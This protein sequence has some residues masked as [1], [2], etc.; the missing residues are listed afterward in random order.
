MSRSARILLLTP[1]YPPAAGGIQQLLGRLV[2]ELAQFEVTVVTRD[3]AGS[4]SWT[5]ARPHRV[6][7][8]GSSQS[9]LGLLGPVALGAVEGLR[10]QF[11]L[12]L[13]GHVTCVPT[14]L[15]LHRLRGQPF[16]V[17]LYADELPRHRHLLAAGLRYAAVTIA[18]SR[19]TRDLAAALGAPVDRTVIVP[20]GVDLPAMPAM[21]ADR[22]PGLV[23]TVARLGDRYKGHDVML[24]ALPHLRKLVPTARW[25]VIGDGPLR[26][27]LEASARR[28][29]VADVV[30]FAGR[31]GD[32]QRDE[33]LDRA[34]VFAMPSRLP[35]RLG[36]EGF[37]IVYLEA[38][39]HGLPVVAGSV[40]GALDAVADG[41]TGL[42]VDPTSPVAVAEALAR[43]LNDRPLARTMALAS[44]RH[45]A[46]FAYDLIADR[47][48]SALARAMR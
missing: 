15:L 5:P 18:I 21:P 3:C 28:L 12:V 22:E 1:D 4:S 6:R 26:A 25:L 31:V 45:A 44:R 42:L 48:A 20:P 7:R 24:E 47:V 30:T 23:V 16:A 41:E 34:E 39:A 33:W 11:D 35:E 46:T 2:E 14:A 17:Y 43:I 9:K 13:A 10:S 37:G 32:K 36:G 8:A 27:E 38:A 19:H 29:G 40:G